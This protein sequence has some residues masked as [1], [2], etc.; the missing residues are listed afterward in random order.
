MDHDQL[1][2][3]SRHILLPEIDVDGQQRL[4]DSTALIVGLGGLGSPAATY[5]ASSGVG[6]LILSDDD[7]VDL[8][9]LQRQI[10]H[11]TAD[12]TRPKTDSAADRLRA[13]NPG[14]KLTTMDRRMS[15]GELAEAVGHANIAI[16]ATDN[17]PARFALNEACLTSRTPLV[18]GA[19]IRMQGQATTFDFRRDDSPCLACLYPERD[20]DDAVENC[21]SGGVLAPAA[22]IVGSIMATEALKLLLEL[23]DTLCGRL[24]QIDAAGMV[25]RQSRLA[26]DP[27]CRLHIV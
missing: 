11:S 7:R 5:L 12:L 27:H 9:N 23:G 24:L 16:D 15:P 20:H 3:Y 21:A 1:Q 4:L 26:R 13:L 17:F 2:R 22:G 14:I 19:V 18:W 25:I 8:G 6:H 10:L